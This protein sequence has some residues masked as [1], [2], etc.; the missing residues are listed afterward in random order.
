M[1]E[2][3]K[4]KLFYIFLI[5]IISLKIVMQILHLY[6][7]NLINGIKSKKWPCADGII[8]RSEIK[9]VLSVDT[10]IYKYF[11]EYEFYVNDEKFTGDKISFEPD[12]IKTKEFL[13]KYTT[14]TQVKVYYNPGNPKQ[15][16]LLPG[17][18]RSL[19]ILLFFFILIIAF[20]TLVIPAIIYS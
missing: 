1:T 2:M 20:L 10:M 14:T 16:V 9:D 19:N 3:T 8:I 12:G 4:E 7:T 5:I 13:K 17:L 15:A 18:F 11:I 6:I